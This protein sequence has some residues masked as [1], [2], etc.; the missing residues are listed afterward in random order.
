MRCK[1]CVVNYVVT[2]TGVNIMR[3][4]NNESRQ[5]PPALEKERA[6]YLR[7]EIDSQTNKLADEWKA[8]P[9]SGLPKPLY[10]E[11][12]KYLTLKS[13]QLEKLKKATASLNQ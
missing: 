2:K 6:E 8:L 4:Y 10:D 3:I 1:F 7:L 12:V 5:F 11:R 9:K 13:E